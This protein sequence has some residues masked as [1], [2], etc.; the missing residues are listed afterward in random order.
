MAVVTPDIVLDVLHAADPTRAAAAAERLATIASAK[1]AASGAFGQLL[2]EAAVDTTPTARS[3][4]PLLNGA[5]SASLKRAGSS[6]QASDPKTEIETLLVSSFVK[7]ALPKDA[8]SVYGKGFAG[9]MWRSMFADQISRQ[10]A[11]SGALSLTKGLFAT[12][13]TGLAKTQHPG[14][15]PD[16]ASPRTTQMSS[17]PLSMSSAVPLTTGSPVEIGRKS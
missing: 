9:D 7:E 2:D 16:A 14:V 17:A 13:L 1:S 8:S 4:S 5:F 12:H 10:V 15:G 6:S 3:A 11:H